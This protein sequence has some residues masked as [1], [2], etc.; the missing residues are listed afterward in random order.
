M[1]DYQLPTTDTV[2]YIKHCYHLYRHTENIDRKGLF[3]S[4]K[5]MQICR[6]TPSYAATSRD[7]IV[8]YLRDAQQGKIPG[9]SSNGTSNFSDSFETES[10]PTKPVEGRSVYTIRPLQ[11]SEFDFGSDDI[12]APIDLTVEQLKSKAVHEKWIGMRVNMWDEGG[13]DLLVKVQY[14]WRLEGNAKREQ[15]GDLPVTSW[16]QCLHD[17]MFLGPKNGTENE[18]GLEILN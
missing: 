9:S 17:I 18:E 15:G 11:C 4:P 5:C 12:I 8:Q 7:G 2:A 3:L 14:W 6:P 1:T 16:R 13:G 10:Q